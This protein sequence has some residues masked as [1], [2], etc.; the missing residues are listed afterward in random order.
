MVEK[1]KDFCKK[2]TGELDYKRIT[3]AK[4]NLVEAVKMLEELE[5]QFP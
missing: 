1:A 3:Q 4:A 5:R 2:A